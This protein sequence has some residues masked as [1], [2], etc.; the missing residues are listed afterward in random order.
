MIVFSRLLISFSLAL[1]ALSMPALAADKAPL[2]INL[3]TD[4]PHRANMAIA[5]GK[6]QFERGHALTIFLNDR[7]VFVGSKAQAGKFASHQKA[8]G[9]LAGKGATVLICPMCMK[10][11]GVG[12]GDLISGV[13][14]G[15]PELTEKALFEGNTK[16]LTW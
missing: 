16:S 6:N 12:E 9:E 2:F 13:R 11:Y 14:V 1:G 8:L 15:N 4:E 7:G 5:F 3:T 10:H